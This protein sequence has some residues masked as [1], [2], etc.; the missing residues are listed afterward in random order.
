MLSEGLARLL[1]LVGC[2]FYSPSFR[3]Q[4]FSETQLPV[5]DFLGNPEGMKRA[6][7][8]LDP[9]VWLLLAYGC[10]WP[11]RQGALLPCSSVLIRFLFASNSSTH[12]PPPPPPGH[13]AFG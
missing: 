9:G 13:A 1:H 11:M 2:P 3:E 6:G 5:L 4:S 8:E 12:L 7:A 10:Y